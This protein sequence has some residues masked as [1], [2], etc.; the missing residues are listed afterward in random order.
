MVLISFKDPTL[1]AQ[2]ENPL[3]LTENP[4]VVQTQEPQVKL[5][6]KWRKMIPPMKNMLSVIIRNSGIYSFQI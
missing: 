4:P 1:Q 3:V 2:A 5:N 6:G